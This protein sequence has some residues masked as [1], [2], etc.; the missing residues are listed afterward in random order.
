MSGRRFDPTP[1]T[2]GHRWME[3][4]SLL[5]ARQP[6]CVS[7][8]GVGRVTAAQEVDHIVPLSQGGTDAPEN[9]QPLCKPCHEEKTRIDMGYKPRRRVGL[10]GCPEGW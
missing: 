5:L 1:R 2:R 7:C 6:L 3:M 8:L 9:L 4:R 10:D